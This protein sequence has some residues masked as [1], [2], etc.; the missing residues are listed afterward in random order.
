MTKQEFIERQQ[1]WKRHSGRRLA[2]WTVLWF[3]LMA[4]V[5]WIQTLVSAR[6][7][8]NWVEPFFVL[9]LLAVLIGNLPVLIWYSRRQQRRFGVVCPQCGKP[10]ATSG[11]SIVVATGNCAY[12]G[13]KILT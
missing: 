10:L 1:A 3:G 4:G 8:A 11:A 7:R 9:L 2:I 6:T 5:I 12:C 13:E